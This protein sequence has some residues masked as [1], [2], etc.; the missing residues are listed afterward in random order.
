MLPASMY[1][2]SEQRHERHAIAARTWAGLGRWQ[3]QLSDDQQRI[4]VRWTRSIQAARR[5]WRAANQR[6][7][8]ASDQ[9]KRSPAGQALA[10]ILARS[11]RA[12]N[13]AESILAAAFERAVQDQAIDAEGNVNPHWRPL[14]PRPVLSGFPILAAL[15]LAAIVVI[16]AFLTYDDYLW[17]RTN[18]PTIL[19]QMQEVQRADAAFQRWLDQGSPGEPP[20]LPPFTPG[21]PQKPPAPTLGVGSAGLGVGIAIAAIAALL[22]MT[23]RP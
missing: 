8:E 12:L 16:V 17:F 1:P 20:P 5:E 9:D 11:D 2:E 14:P 19:R 6:Y 4:A 3:P 22:L 23:S 13:Q 10:A 15:A 7:Q 21:I 18:E